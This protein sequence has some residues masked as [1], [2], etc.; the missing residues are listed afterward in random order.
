MRSSDKLRY[1]PGYSSRLPGC[2]LA[3]GAL[4]IFDYLRGTG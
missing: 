4:S 2:A 3:R 1:A